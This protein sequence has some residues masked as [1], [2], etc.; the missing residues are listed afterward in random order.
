MPSN[1]EFRCLKLIIKK[2]SRYLFSNP[3]KKY[4]YRV[5]KL[6]SATETIERPALSLEGVNDVERCDGLALGVLAVRD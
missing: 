3:I 2:K 5:K 6:C 4:V 1:A